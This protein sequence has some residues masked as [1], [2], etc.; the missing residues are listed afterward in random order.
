MPI[1]TDIE[2]KE[3]TEHD[4]QTPLQTTALY[5]STSPDYISNTLQFV[6]QKHRMIKS[7]LIKPQ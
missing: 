3:L 1:A 4:I 6:V 7:E 5:M 2:K